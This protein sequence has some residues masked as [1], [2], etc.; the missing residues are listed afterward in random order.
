VTRGTRR[1]IRRVLCRNRGGRACR[2]CAQVVTGF[3]AG[4]ATYIFS[5]QLK[6][7]FG[8]GVPGILPQGTAVPAEFLEKV[9]RP[10][11]DVCMLRAVDAC[12]GQLLVAPDCDLNFV[13]AP[14][15]WPS[16]AT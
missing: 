5:T 3:T 2:G 8:L 1:S 13:A 12:T 16:P 9:R 14:A 11:C 6:D 15:T 4:I 7:F 10:W